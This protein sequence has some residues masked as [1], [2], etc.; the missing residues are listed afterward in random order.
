[1]TN[2]IAALPSRKEGLMRLA[3]SAGMRKLAKA[4]NGFKFCKNVART[5]PS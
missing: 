4:P 5:Q 1:M 2:A 3:I